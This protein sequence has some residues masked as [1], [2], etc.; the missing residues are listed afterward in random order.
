MAPA[1]RPGQSD[2]ETQRRRLQDLLVFEADVKKGG[3]GT[4]RKIFAN[5]LIGMNP[6]LTVSLFFG[7]IAKEILLGAMAVIYNSSET[8]LG[9][10]ISAAFT[11]LQSLSFMTFVLIY[12]PCLGIIAAQLQ[13]SK[14]RGFALLSLGWSLSLAWVMALLDYQGGML[15]IAG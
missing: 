4:P 1:K 7:F 6:A 12:T 8:M 9:A 15:I 10:S 3:A 11:P 13:E 2:N 14:S 5:L